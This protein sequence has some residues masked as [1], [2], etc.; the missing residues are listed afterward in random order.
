MNIRNATHAINGHR[1]IYHAFMD[2]FVSFR[3]R[4]TRYGHTSL[5]L[6]IGPSVHFN[7]TS[8]FAHK[9]NATQK[10]YCLVVIRKQ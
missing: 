7:N 9:K 2:V 5:F 3:C 10:S 8:L 1:A 6:S 4:P